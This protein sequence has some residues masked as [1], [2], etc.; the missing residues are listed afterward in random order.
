M[1]V[2][3][4]LTHKRADHMSRIT[5]GEKPIGVDDDLPDATLFQIESVPQWSHMIAEFLSTTIF[6]TRYNNVPSKV[7]FLEAYSRFQLISGRL[8]HLM[9]DGVMRLVP[10]PDEYPSIV[11]EAHVTYTDHHRSRQ[12]TITQILCS[13]YWWPTMNFHVATFVTKVCQPCQ[14]QPVYSHATLYKITAIPGW[15]KDIVECL[16]SGRVAKD[17]PMH[18]QKQLQADAK[19]Y[20]L[21][22]D[23]LYKKGID[24]QLLLC[25]GDKEYIPILHQAHSG[26]GSGHFSSRTTAKNIIWSGIWWPTLFHDAEAFVKRCEECQRSKVPNMFDRMPLR[27]MI[28]TRAFAKWGLDFVGPIKP[29]AKGTHAE[30][31]LVATDYLTKWVEAKATI[32]NDARTTAK[33]LYE[34]IFTRYGLPI[35]LVSDQGTH[36]INEVIEYLLREFMVIHHKSAPYHPQ[37]NGQAES[38]NKVLCIALTKVVEGSRSDW[39][40]KINSVLW[41]YRTSYKT[42]INCTPYELVFGLNAILPIDFLIPTLRVANLGMER[43]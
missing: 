1:A 20:T 30:Y 11:K 43:A 3:K 35:E 40:L 24:G 26:V 13:G 2:K 42:A 31:I 29:P 6:N 41:A 33:F 37:A 9:N 28:S 23:Q 38:T 4:G 16:K 21:V 10:N 5:N 39:E 34:N 7:Q 18:R 8:Y 15:A 12:R 17:V 14:L 27:P 32:K 22:G 19:D 25:A 36:F